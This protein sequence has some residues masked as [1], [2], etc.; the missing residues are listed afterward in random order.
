MHNELFNPIDIF[1]YHPH[2]L[3]EA[4]GERLA[5]SVLTR[6]LFPNDFLDFIWTGTVAGTGEPIQPN[7]RAVGFKSFPD[8]WIDVRN[9]GFWQQ[10]LLEDFPVKK[11]ILFRQDELAVYVSMKRSKLTASYLTHSY[12]ATL[13][14]TID[15][16]DFQIFINN[17]RH[18]YRHKYRSPVEKRDTF[19][20]TYEQLVEEQEFES[21]ILP[22]LWKFLGVD[23]TRPL[24]KLKET[25]KQAAPD[26]DL[27]DI[28]KNYSELEFCFRHSDVLHFSKKREANAALI[29]LTAP[30]P[31]LSW[32][33]RMIWRLGRC[34]FPFVHAQEF[35]RPS[36]FTTTPAVKRRKPSI[37]AGF[38]TLR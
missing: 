5:W 27:S 36:L 14:L 4:T 11:I 9:E 3:K 13:K 6:D 19:W 7:S 37:P 30:P 10:Q 8:H 29:P 21:T 24:K 26:E 1:T 15:P 31:K 18:T 2:M 38:W 34:F 20:I 32:K 28:I 17:Y 35:R 23:S 12:P 25:V 22:E 16:A 33:H